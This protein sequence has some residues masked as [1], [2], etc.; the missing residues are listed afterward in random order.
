MPDD[1]KT[2]PLLTVDSRG[3]VSLGALATHA[4]YFVSVEEDGVIVLTPAV[5]MT[6]TE[7]SQMVDDFLENP[8]E[9]VTENFQDVVPQPGR[10]RFALSWYI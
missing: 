4:R 5:V 8:L 3:R 7:V 2:R 1:D 6:A 10:R 9:N